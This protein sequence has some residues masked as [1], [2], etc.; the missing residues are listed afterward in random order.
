M[1]TLLGLSGI[2]IP[3][4]VEGLDY[5]GHLRGEE[6]LDVKAALIMC[7]V[8]FHQWSYA[9][10]GREFRGVRTKQYTYVRDLNGPWLLY[11]NHADPYQLNNLIGQAGNESLQ[12]DLEEELNALLEKT[13]DQFLSAVELMELWDYDWDDKDQTIPGL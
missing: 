12:A 2:D 8:P 9:K 6:E 3:E 7:P 4:S 1:P 10:G 5:S 11:D 13:G